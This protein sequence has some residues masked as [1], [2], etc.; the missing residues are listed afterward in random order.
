MFL[1]PNNKILKISKELSVF[2]ILPTSIQAQ[3]Q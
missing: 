2:H 1:Y 3:V